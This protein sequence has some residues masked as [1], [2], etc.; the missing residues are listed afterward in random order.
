M[1]KIEPSAATPAAIP[2]W[3]KVELMPEAMPERRGSTTP[4]ATAASG[5]LNRPAPTPAT[6]SPGTRW[7]Q[8]EEAEIPRISR[9]PIPTRMNPG[10]MESRAGTL[11]LSRPA[12]PALRKIAPLRT[13][14][15][16]PV[17]IAE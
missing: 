3:R 9:R 2:T 10:P 7:V 14:S 15:R 6:I 4:T 17:A 11:E 1:A 13:S 5:V 16:S 12:M 8:P